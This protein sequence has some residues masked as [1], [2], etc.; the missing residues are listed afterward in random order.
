MAEICDPLYSLIITLEEL[1]PN[2]PFGF[3]SSGTLSPASGTYLLGSNFQ[4]CPHSHSKGDSFW[5]VFTH[6]AKGFWLSPVFLSMGKDSVTWLWAF[7]HWAS[8]L[9]LIAQFPV[10]HNTPLGRCLPPTYGG[11]IQAHGMKEQ[12]IHH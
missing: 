5:L 2:L 10:V 9:N 11:S 1:I 12:S 3:L 6:K 7:T 8:A 4:L